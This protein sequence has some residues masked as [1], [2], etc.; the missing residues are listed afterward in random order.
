MMIG[1]G[2]Y[3][4]L[5]TAAREAAKARGIILIVF[6]GDKG[7]GFSAQLDALGT[8]EIPQILREIADE[9][10]REWRA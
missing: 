7:S 5:A 8:M 3:D 4:A 10:E 6:G 1:P 2:K 9:I